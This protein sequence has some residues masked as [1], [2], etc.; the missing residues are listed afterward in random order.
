M[1]VTK[2]SGY[3]VRAVALAITVTVVA[4]ERVV[5]AGACTFCDQI[6]IG[7]RVFGNCIQSL[8]GYYSCYV[9]DA[10][11]GNSYCNMS[12]PPCTYC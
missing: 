3:L 5:P 9:F 10:G 11:N 1:R 7:D 2:L 4:Q 6:V 12:G 8:F